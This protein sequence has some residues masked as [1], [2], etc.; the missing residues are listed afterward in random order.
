VYV[1][2]TRPFLQGA[3]LTTW[4]LL[5]AKIDQTLVADSMAGYLMQNGEVDCVLVGAD[6]IVANG[7]VANKIGTY[8]L[9]VLAR[10]HNLPFYVAAPSSTIDLSCPHGDLIP[11]EERSSSEVTHRG[12]VQLAPEGIAAEHP[13]FDITPHELVTAII[14]EHGVIYPPF[15][16]GL[17]QH[18]AKH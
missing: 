12:D 7:D 1:D 15:D 13:A 14:T 11:I 4:E 18:A 9:A 6:R 2:E 5:Q 17:R 16:Q 8:T 10:E 3:R